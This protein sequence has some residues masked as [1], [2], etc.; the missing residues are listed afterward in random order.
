MPRGF[1]LVDQLVGLDIGVV[2]GSGNLHC[3]E[4]L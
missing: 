4:V 3:L 1:K 2:Q